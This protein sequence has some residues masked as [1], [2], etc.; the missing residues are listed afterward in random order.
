MSF[1]S[2]NGYA[3]VICNLFRT[4]VL[5]FLRQGLT[6]FCQPKEY[7]DYPER[8]LVL[9]N[10]RGARCPLGVLDKRAA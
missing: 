6:L 3:K 4:I 5:P 1:Y 10:S 8:S 2:V 9:A 7:A